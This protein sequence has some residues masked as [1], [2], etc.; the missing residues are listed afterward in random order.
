MNPASTDTRYFTR[1]HVLSFA[2]MIAAF[3][4]LSSCSTT[5]PVRILPAGEQALNVSLGG[6]IV[7]GESPVGFI[8]YFDVG[9]VRGLSDNWTMQ[10]DLHALPAVFGTFGADVGMATRLCR[11]D[12]WRPEITAKGQALVFTDF[13]S[14]RVYPLLSLIGSYQLK[15]RT[16]A[17]GGLETVYQF[18]GSR[19]YLTPLLGLQFPLS[20]T[21]GMQTELKWMASNVNTHSGIFE[22]TGSI[23]SHGGIAFFVG[24]NY[25]L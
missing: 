15:P 19:V 24:L 5:H 1:V 23:S 11:E 10:A 2:F 21:I 4:A 17:Y 16:L 20:N 22:G 3:L 18:N 25:A 8:P 13:T 12:G 9:Y 7:P 6:P 14:A